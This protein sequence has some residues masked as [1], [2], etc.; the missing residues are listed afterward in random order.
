MVAALA[1]PA[2]VRRSLPADSGFRGLPIKRR[3]LPVIDL[4]LMPWRHRHQCWLFKLE[5]ERHEKAEMA[6]WLFPLV[7]RPVRGMA[8]FRNQRAS[9]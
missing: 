1:R 5:G 6:P 4:V 3:G 2:A 9:S 7:A 8:A